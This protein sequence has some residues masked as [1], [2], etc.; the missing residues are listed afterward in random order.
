MW[1]GHLLLQAQTANQATPREIEDVLKN[2]PPKDLLKLRGNTRK[3]ASHQISSKLLDAEVNKESTFKLKVDQITPWNFPQQGN[4]KGWRGHSTDARIRSGGVTIETNI[5]LYIKQ[6]PKNL[7]D[8][9]RPGAELIVTGKV[10]R[11]DIVVPGK[12]LLNMDIQVSD[13][14]EAK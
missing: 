10:S 12:T 6:D 5:Y 4:V 9:I 11:C 13:F 7:L 14:A 2:I 3:E 8:K 1:M